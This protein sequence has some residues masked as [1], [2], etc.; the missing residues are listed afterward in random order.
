M[1]KRVIILVADG[2]VF[3]RG[4]PLTLPASINEADA[5]HLHVADISLLLAEEQ[6]NFYQIIALP[7]PGTR[8]A[9]A[10]KSIVVDVPE[11]KADL[12]LYDTK[13]SEAKRYIKKQM[14]LD[15]QKAEEDREEEERDRE[16]DEEEEEEQQETSES[17]E[18]AEQSD[19][20]APAQV[21]APLPVA[22]EVAAP[23]PIIGQ[24]SPEAIGQLEAVA[25][26]PLQFPVD[27]EKQGA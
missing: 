9:E 20:A 10:D 4:K 2:L 27:E 21:S 14:Q 7:I 11:R 1:D 23:I 8:F 5:K 19:P 17:T 22:P 26:I 6:E 24:L 13:A 12:I 18:E 16:D 25:P 3:Q 15:E